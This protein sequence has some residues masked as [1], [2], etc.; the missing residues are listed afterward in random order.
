MNTLVAEVGL[1]LGK[2]GQLIHWPYWLGYF[3]GLF[4]D[5]LA[6]VSRRKMS[7][8]SIRIRKFCSNTM[9]DSANI[10]KTDFRSPVPLVEGLKKTIKYEFI[11][12]TDGQVFY[13]E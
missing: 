2:Q 4:F 9:F 11:D 8:S 6:V 3:V 13:T 1:A 7:V 5:V 12:K 10:K